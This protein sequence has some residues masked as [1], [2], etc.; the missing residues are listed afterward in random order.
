[1]EEVF[2]ELSISLISSMQSLRILAGSE[3]FHRRSPSWVFDWGQQVDPGIWQRGSKRLRSY[4]RYAAAG[5]TKC[6]AE[7]LGSRFLKVKGSAIDVV[8][9]VGEEMCHGSQSLLQMYQ[10]ALVVSHVN[11]N[12][13]A[14]YKG[15]GTWEVA[16]WRTLCMDVMRDQTTPGIELSEEHEQ[17]MG[18][19]ISCR[20]LMLLR[21]LTGISKDVASMAA[22]RSTP[23]LNNL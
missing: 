6:V 5:K 23:Y 10:K 14:K 16:F 13:N 1:V 19:Y 7:F 4:D 3:L 2:K 21:G 15:G 18:T 20:R 12:A 8:M 11:G 9:V 22:S 17:R